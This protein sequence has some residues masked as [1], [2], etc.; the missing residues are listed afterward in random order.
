[1]TSTVLSFAFALVS[2]AG[3]APAPPA[4]KV[5]P[6]DA[7][8]VAITPKTVAELNMGKLKGVIRLLVWNPDATKV[9]LQTADLQPNAQI[10]TAYHHVI[11][12]STGAVD[13]V[14]AVPDWAQEALA[15]KTGK[16]APG[17]A[18]FAID[19]VIEQRRNAATALPMGGA[20][21]PGY[22]FYM[23]TPVMVNSSI[24]QY[25]LRLTFGQNGQLQAWKKVVQ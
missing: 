15:W 22:G 20:W 1:M 10:K 2:L 21:G 12:A 16:T 3:Q 18:S 11:D 9:Y 23:P 24:T 4:V 5:A 6:I 25:C 19:L 8:K 14:S 17:D 7:A 13:T